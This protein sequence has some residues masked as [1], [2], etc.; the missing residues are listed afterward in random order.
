MKA[1]VSW[2]GGKDCMLALYRFL[3]NNE[4]EV[5][6]LVNMCDAETD[7][8]CSHGLPKSIIVSQAE[9]LNIPL[10]QGYTD[11]KEYENAFKKIILDLSDQGISAGVFGDI[12]LMEHRTWIERVCS[13]MNI[14]AIFPLW[15]NNT[16]DLLHEFIKAGF[17]A[18]TVSVHSQMLSQD[19]LG[20]ELDQA[21]FNEITSLPK[22]D[23]CAENGE[24]HSFVYD[25]PLFSTPVPFIKGAINHHDNHYFLNISINETI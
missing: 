20:K 21:F 10:I 12:Y 1:F 4:N 22:I 15:G 7:Y 13:D 19:W 16:S 6:C 5:A 24:Y 18:L 2:S 3:K 11:S 17:K 14:E 23:P 25:G 8:S 9:K